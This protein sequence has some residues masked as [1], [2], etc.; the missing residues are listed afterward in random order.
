[1]ITQLVARKWESALEPSYN[2]K[3]I[4]LTTNSSKKKALNVFLSYDKKV[5]GVASVHLLKI[6]FLK[7]TP[8]TLGSNIRFTFSGMSV[9]NRYSAGCFILGI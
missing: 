4:A 8:T 1:M 2:S 6:Y 3:M 5:N 7:K 9:N